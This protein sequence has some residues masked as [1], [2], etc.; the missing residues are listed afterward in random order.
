[1]NALRNQSGFSLVELLVASV[2][3]LIMMGGMISLMRVSTSLHNSTQQG[4]ELQENVRSA[5]NIISSELVNAG[6]GLV[7]TD[8]ISGIPPVAVPAGARLGPLGAAVASGSVPF[9]M[10]CNETGQAV[11][12]D[13]EG[14]ALAA[15]IQTDMLVFLGGMGQGRFVKQ[16]APGPTSDYGANVFLEDNSSFR[17]GQLILVENGAQVSLGQITQVLANGGLQFSNGDPLGTNAP[18]SISS[19]NP[20][21]FAAQQA[22]GG[23]PPMVYPLSSITYFIDSATDPR[24]PMLKRVANSAGGAAAGIAV[25][26]NIENFQ[27][28]Y[29]VDSDANAT[30]PNVSSDLPAANQLSLIRA[31]TVT[32]TGR[33]QV[34]MGD[35]NFADHHSRLTMSQTIFFRNNVRR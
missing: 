28:S 16:S 20:N 10:P 22:N 25:A 2:V 4:L 31:A 21:F 3:F 33:S 11:S 18:G 7:F 29:L 35:P 32:I 1:M 19:P 12:R 17:Q 9:I 30:T 27:V 23:P 26:D 24:H 13:G 14:N 15:S 5:L 6:S 8:T 34:T